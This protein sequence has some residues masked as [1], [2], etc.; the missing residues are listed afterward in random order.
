M[1]H[2]LGLILF[3]ICICVSAGSKSIMDTLNFHFGISIFK[4]L[5]DWWNPEKSWKLKWKN[6][7]QGQG[8][9]FPGSSTIF[10]SLTDGWHF[11]QHLFLT[12]IFLSVIFYSQCFPLIDWKLWFISDFL[13]VYAGFTL[14]FELIFRTFK[15]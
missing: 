5:G 8:E 12:F 14:T 1:T 6:G 15:N 2:T 10:V 9:R 7:D 4:D 3:V 13:I 11:F